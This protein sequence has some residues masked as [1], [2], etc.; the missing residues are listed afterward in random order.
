MSL[1]EVL[2]RHI[3]SASRPALRVPPIGEMRRVAFTPEIRAADEKKRTITFVASTESTDRYGDVIRVAG[4]QTNNYLRN[5][6]VLWAHRSSD[7]PIGK[8]L[9]LTTETNPPALVQ[10][11]EFAD[12]KTYPFAD[13][14]FKLYK[15]KFLRSVS[16]G[17]KPLVP[18]TPIMDKEGRMTGFE[19]NGQELLELSCVPLPANP[20]AVARAVSEGIITRTDARK[21]FVENDPEKLL[22]K[23]RLEISLQ[24]LELSL[25]DLQVDLLLKS[26]KPTDEITS[27]EQLFST[28]AARSDKPI[29]SLDQLDAALRGGR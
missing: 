24:Q 10:V 16:V 18:P 6:V 15:Q 23:A 2:H 21:F 17:F 26:L 1:E 7:P 27:L 4:W 9:A 29:I 14:I 8:T 5:P 25:L 3:A 19:F 22:Q 28:S 13:Q 20:D 11:V 12:G